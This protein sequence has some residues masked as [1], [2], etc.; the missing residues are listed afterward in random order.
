MA[1]VPTQHFAPSCQ[2]L[3]G[4]ALSVAQSAH[5]RTDS[6]SFPHRVRR[7]ILPFSALFGNVAMRLGRVGGLRR[8]YR[9]L[10]GN[11]SWTK[12]SRC[13]AG[14]LLCLSRVCSP[15]NG[16][17]GVGIGVRVSACKMPFPRQPPL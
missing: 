9:Q 6:I 8:P 17:S 14:R 16:W 5:L 4:H 2:R 12:E 1:Q 11:Y 10:L 3:P 15:S 13:L 7:E